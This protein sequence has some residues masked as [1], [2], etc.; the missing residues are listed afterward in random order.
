MMAPALL[1]LSLLQP[2]DS[3]ARRDRELVWRRNG[4]DKYFRVCSD[5]MD[6][7]SEMGKGTHLTMKFFCKVRG[8]GEGYT[9]K[10]KRS[11]DDA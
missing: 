10:T 5:E 11:R 2:G 9:G 6:L 8:G 1:T 4:I 7:R 3:N